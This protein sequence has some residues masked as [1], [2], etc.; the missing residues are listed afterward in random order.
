[1]SITELCKVTLYGTTADRPKVLNE[2]QSLA[3][4][5]LIPLQEQKESLVPVPLEQADAARQAL[6]YLLNAPHRRHQV[7]EED[8]FQV[9]QV[10]QAVLDNWLATASGF[11]KFLTIRCSS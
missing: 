1:M 2:L 9:E 4:M 8:T 3:C 5:H 11:I 10:I 7:L 6:R